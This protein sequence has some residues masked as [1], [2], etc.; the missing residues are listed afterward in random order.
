MIKFS[1]LMYVNLEGERLWFN[2]QLHEN[3]KKIGVEQE[4]TGCQKIA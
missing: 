2:K 1:L 3:C 4:H